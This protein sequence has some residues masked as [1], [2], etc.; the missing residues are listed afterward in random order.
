MPGNRERGRIRGRGGG[1]NVLDTLE[2]EL[3]YDR[4][5]IVHCGG[6]TYLLCMESYKV[7]KR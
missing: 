5:N 7:G 2:V 3:M 1:R 6:S 4:L